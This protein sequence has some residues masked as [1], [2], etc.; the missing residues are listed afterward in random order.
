MPY[1]KRRQKLIIEPVDA[2][3]KNLTDI[4]IIPQIDTLF[5]SA[6]SLREAIDHLICPLK[7][8][9]K[10][11]ATGYFISDEFLQNLVKQ[12][13]KLV[14][15]AY[16]NKY[17]IGWC[18]EI[19]SIVVAY[20]LEIGE[21]IRDKFFPGLSRFLNS[22]GVFKRIWGEVRQEF[23]QNAIQIGGVY[24]DVSN[25]T[26]DIRK[27]KTERMWLNNSEFS[28]FESFHCYAGILQRYH[29]K[30]IF[31]NNCL[32]ELAP[33][34]PFWTRVENGPLCLDYSFYM[35]GLAE[36][37]DYRASEDIFETRPAFIND[38]T[39]ELLSSIESI[40]LGI[41]GDAK[42]IKYF[43]FNIMDDNARRNLFKTY[44]DMPKEHRCHYI[45]HAHHFVK[46]I[47]HQLKLL[48]RNP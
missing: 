43:R 1:D 9:N 15:P 24:L 32:P 3:Q 23:F 10:T 42:T 6:T 31:I 44:R 33:L 46:L 30:E 18:H 7:P 14:A 27:P 36:D 16:L 28:S 25:D 34:C 17:P 48:Y 40:T 38:L 12:R 8:F 11:D 2:N 35:A 45:D 19:T 4:F 20:L 13:I 47:N 39:I 41:R 5:R 29:K 26:V 37:T 22:G 21:A